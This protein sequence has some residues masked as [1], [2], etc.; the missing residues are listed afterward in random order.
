SPSLQAIRSAAAAAREPAT[1]RVTAILVTYESRADVA[2]ALRSID[3]AFAV[4][5]IRGDIIVVDNAS[6]DGTPDWIRTERPDVALILA[7]ANEG[8]GRACNR[9]F[10]TASGDVWL[11]VNPDARLE[12]DAVAVL[13]AELER[14]P[15]VAAI[16]PTLARAGEAESAGMLPGAAS[17]AGHFLLLNRL[18]RFGA[19]GSWRGFQLRRQPI[20]QLIPVDWVSAAVVALRPAAIRAVGGFNPAFFLYGEDIDLCARLRGAGWSIGLSTATRADHAIGA[21]SDPRSTRWLDGLDQAM[22][23]NGRGRAARAAFFASVAIGLAVRVAGNAVRRRSEDRSAR[24]VP[25]VRRAAA[26]A[27]RS[28]APGHG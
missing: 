25:S 10:E 4:P 24:L 8:F 17:G 1:T 15:R 20:G 27:A 2:D 5:A 14:R 18:P 26:L 13:A 21:S 19:R 3:R 28:V 22:R 9:A 23:A 7:P 6:S 12:P 16:G 11:L